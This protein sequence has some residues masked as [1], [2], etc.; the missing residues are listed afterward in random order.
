MLFRSTDSWPLP[1]IFA[2]G[3]SYNVLS[4]D[5]D[6]RWLLSSDAV[7]PNNQSTYGN[8]GTELVWNDIISLRVGYNSLLKADAEEGLTAGV[9]VQ[10]DFGS[11][12]A[13]FDYSYSDFG[14]FDQI[15]RFSLSVGI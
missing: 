5:S 13:K 6:W 8:L 9:G 10:Y 7:V 4:R 12:F 11:F 15:S 3:L 14:V 2:V 1:L